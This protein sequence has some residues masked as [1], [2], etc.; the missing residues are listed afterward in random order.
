MITLGL[1]VAA[2]A[3]DAAIQKILG[4]G[5]TTV[6]ISNEEMEDVMKIVKSIEE[7]GL[8]IKDISKTIKIFSEFY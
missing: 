8:L 1:T 4:S 2:S 5:T 7:S 3:T 6:I